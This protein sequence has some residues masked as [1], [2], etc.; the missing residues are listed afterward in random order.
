MENKA[1]TLLGFASKSGKLGFGFAS[2]KDSLNRKKSRLIICAYDLSEKSK[3]EALFYAGKNSID[4][5][6]LKTTD[7]FTLSNAV[8]HKCG[9][10]SVNDDGFAKSIKEEILNDQQI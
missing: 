8:G 2:C 1:L 7:I 4:V 3:K 6:T 10:L 9:I 5:L